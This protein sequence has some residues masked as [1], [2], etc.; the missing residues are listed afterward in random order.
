MYILCRPHITADYYVIATNSGLTLQERQRID[1]RLNK[2]TESVYNKVTERQ[3]PVYPRLVDIHLDIP[4]TVF[5]GSPFSVLAR[6]D[7]LSLT[8]QL[9]SELVV[10]YENHDHFSITHDEI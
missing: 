6:I 7:S 9:D 1:Q 2:A 3:L 4:E 10:T 5:Q 8:T